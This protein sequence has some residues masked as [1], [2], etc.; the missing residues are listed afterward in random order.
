MNPSGQSTVSTGPSQNF[1]SGSGDQMLT[2]PPV[3]AA[4]DLATWYYNVF[5]AQQ[6]QQQSAAAMN[7]R[8]VSQPLTQTPVLL[9]GP[10]QWN[11]DRRVVSGPGRFG[12][13]MGQDSQGG[14]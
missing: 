13:F 8:V 1:T 9:P 14:M 6:Q 11:F 7:G 10:G 2:G 5:A 12:G 3:Q 4:A